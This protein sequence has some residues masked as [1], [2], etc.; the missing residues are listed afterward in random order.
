[1]KLKFLVALGIAATLYSCDDETTGIGQFV[2]DAD[3][4]PAKADSYTIET[5]SYL[6][7]SVYSRSSTAYLGKFT[8]KDYGTFSSDFLVQINCPENFILPDRIEEIKTA[9]LGLYYTSYF[10]DSLAS[11]RVQIDPL[12]KAIKDDGT[13]KALYYSNLDPTEYYDKNATPL[14]IKDYSAY[15]RTI[16]DSVRNEDGYY[17]NVAI[18]LGDG[19]CKNFL[20][21]YNYTE[22]VNG[23]TIHPYFKDS[24]SFINNVLK[25][26]YVHTISGEGSILYISDIYLHLTIAYWTKT[27]E[28]K[29]TLVHTVVPMSSTKEVFMS[30]RFKNSGMKEL[31]SD[32]KCTY[33]KT[34]AG[35][36]TEVTLPIEEMYQAHKN[37][38]LNSISVSFQKLKDQSNNP[39]KMGTPSNL[40][41]VRKGEMKD[42]FEN[43][44]VYDNKTT[45]I[46]TYSST[47]NS[48]DFSK[49]NRLISYIFSEIR[50]EI[51]KGEA[52]WNKWKSEHQD[53]NKLLLVPVT[54]ES[55]SQG[56]IIGVENDLNVNSAMLMGG[57]DLNNS[58][59][60]SQRIRMSII[61]TNPV[62]K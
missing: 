43:N 32:P 37:D 10:G 4:I 26:F 13:N 20:E 53:Y 47:T 51:E 24:E 59:D 57:K 8:D 14:A 22:T 28:D 50:P 42:F 41:M 34:P 15:D 25:G 52:E 2:A 21:K 12:T 29:D 44:K 33:L 56:N 39:F 35:L 38:T 36:C 6:L 55:D 3:M 48:Y 46:A 11:I 7:D 18:D 5:E 30:T 45:F 62:Q 60:E 19:F 31:V 61:Y 17:P 27:S 9:K 58:S 54:T 1:M 16:P 49:L 40:L 23:K